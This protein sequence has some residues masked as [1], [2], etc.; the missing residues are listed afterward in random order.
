MLFSNGEVRNSKKQRFIKEQEAN[1]LL[2]TLE[3]K[4]PLNKAPLVCPLLF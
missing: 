4:S 2:G 3:L 1:G